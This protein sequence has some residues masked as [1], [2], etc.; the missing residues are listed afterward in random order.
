[1]TLI[2]SINEEILALTSPE[3]V[4]QELLDSE[5]YSLALDIKIRHARKF[6]QQIQNPQPSLNESPPLSS[7]TLNAEC[8][9]YIPQ[10][11]YTHSLHRPFQ[12]AHATTSHMINFQPS[13]LSTASNQSHQLP[14]LAL[15]TF[16][17]NILE[18][19]TFW[20]SYESAVHENQMLTN[21]QK[22]NYLKAQLRDE[23]LESITGF[24]LT[25]ANY[26][27]AVSVLTDRFG[28]TDKIINSYM[29]AL[30]E[31]QQPKNQLTSLRKFY[32]KMES[33]VRGL[34]A[35]GQSQE[36]YGKL[37]VPII[38]NKLPGEVRR[39]LAREHKS[40]TWMLRDLRKSI[41]EEI[42]IMDA[43]QE[44]QA[45]QSIPTTSFF[46]AGTKQTKPQR[47]HT[48]HKYA[49]H[50]IEKRPCIFCKD[51]HAPSA[52][53][54]VTDPTARMNIVKRD[55]LCFN[56]LGNHRIS[57]CKSKHTCKT[58]NKKHHT[59]LCSGRQNTPT[60]TRRNDQTE[61]SE[62]AVNKKDE[63][64]KVFHSQA[65]KTRS[66]VL[67][68]TAVAAVGSRKVFV[69]TNI[70]FDEGAQ[71]SFITS[72]LAKKLNLQT[73][74]SEEL[75]LS[76][77]GG[78]NN[79]SR[80]LERA[81]VYLKTDTGYRLP[82]NVLI[83]PR[84]ATPLHSNRSQ[85]DHRYEYLRGLKLAHPVCQDDAFEI[86]LLVGA[87]YY[88]D[89]IED[90]IVRGNGPTAV[91]SKIGYLLS[92]PV[93]RSEN[94]GSPTSSILNV[95]LSHKPE[96]FNLE[97]FWK[98]ESIGINSNETDEES[99]T[100]LE[101]YQENSIEFKD[102]K[103][104]AGLPWKKEHDELPT[105]FVVT[106][107]R[108]E[109]VI[110]R[111]SQKPDLLQ[112][113]G[114]IIADQERR[115]FIE[116]V[117][118]EDKIPDKVH[119]IPHHPVHKDSA[120]TPIR[121]VFDC[122]CRQSQHS[123]SLNDCLLDVPPKLNDLT[124]LLI[125]FRDNPV[126]IT[127]DI[128][129]AFLHVGLKEDDRDV[130][131]FLWLSDPSDPASS[132][133]TYR[134]KSVLFG[135]SCSPFILNATLLKHLRQNTC[136]TA[137][138]MER[139]LYVDNILSSVESDDE[140]LTY[141]TEARQI[142]AEAGF[143][144]RTWSSN[145]DKLRNLAREENV[146]DMDRNTKVLGMLWNSENDNL[147]YPE[148]N[149]SA[150]I[151]E[152]VTKRAILKHSSQ[153]YDPLGLLTPVTIRAKTLI[154]DLWKGGFDWDEKVPESHRKT[155]TDLV[156]DIDEI[157]ST[158]IPRTYFS[159]KSSST[160]DRILHVFTDA[161]LKAYGS[162]A[163][164]SNGEE[165]SLVMA[166][167]RVAPL[168]NLTLPQLELMAAV[169]GSRL[170]THIQQTLEITNIVFWSDSSIVLHWLKS[171][172]P[173]KR[174]VANRVNEITES[175][176]KYEWRYCPTEFN[177]ADLVT[178]GIT[179]KH[180]KESR[181][182]KY[183]PSWLTYSAK[184]P[185][186]KIISKTVMTTL[187]DDD[188]DQIEEDKEQEKNIGNIIN[189]QKYG[190][191]NTLIRITAYVQR[192]V[193][194]CTHVQN[195]RRHGTLKPCEIDNAT[196]TWISHTQRLVYAKE[197]SVLKD[198]KNTT[199]LARIRQLGLFMDDSDLIRCRGRINNA[200]IPDSAKYPLLMSANEQ[201][202]KLLIIDAHERTLHSG[203]NAT[204]TYVRQ[205]FWIPALRQYVKKIL[206]KCV[207]C[208]KVSG[209][210]YNA[211][212]AP[213]LPKIRLTEAPPFTVTGVDYTGA[214]LVRNDSGTLQKAYICLFTCASTR[215]VHL[216]VVPNLTE[217]SFVQ[218][219]RRFVSRKS[220]P[221]TL[222]SDNATTFISGSEEIK[223]LCDSEYIQETLSKHGI[224]WKFI[225][226]RAPWYG[227][228]WER[229]I[230]LTKTSLKKTL[231]RSQITMETLRTIVTEIETIL[232]DRPL[233]YPSSDI[234]DY[235]PLTPAHLL[236]GRKITS[237]PYPQ[238]DIEES[239]L[240]DISHHNVNKRVERQTLLIQHFW[241]RWK[242]EYLTSLR[243]FHR[244]TGKTEQSIREGD[245]VQIHDETPRT[246]WKLGLVKELVR[247]KDGLVRSVKIRT[248]TGE[249]TR[250][251]I[252]LY[253]LEISPDDT[254]TCASNAG[255]GSTRC[256]T[257]LRMRRKASVKARDNIRRWTN[258]SNPDDD[259]DVK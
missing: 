50:S 174:F 232:N 30:L 32:D 233:T 168:K 223:R 169:I 128:E 221:R 251:I 187:M 114:E 163:Y 143:N 12:N 235:E 85:I 226:K 36:T 130:T 124:K 37:L 205:S 90:H 241:R 228:F 190:S 209:R 102:N 155:W 64:T 45:P 188:R 22:F 166:K 26:E 121:I 24:A 5:D 132:L 111:L 80:N 243:E 255:G 167:T 99:D 154:Q 153:I 100:F 227:G 65:T 196:K 162:A 225:P 122:S 192:F 46:H 113:Y 126:A 87:D 148:R 135:A 246:N 202:S 14:K 249:T 212:T 245:I 184:W 52:C 83:V 78:E 239:D 247:G 40:N 208:K 186:N 29:Q 242:T 178:R 106:K 107:R 206:N 240:T 108:T 159:K 11:T 182:W 53:T 193:Y 56:C 1:M 224:E 2:D 146:L 140:A 210:P 161:S 9:P 142:M 104:F 136:K 93:D 105:N 197:Y 112:K 145:S 170:A 31:I 75:H 185:D 61:A 238:I 72:E 101:S 57:E 198:K 175:T 156:T 4:E 248:R 13:M 120:T 70:L 96:E 191:Y 92:G 131:R 48:T 172:K 138:T 89:I 115:G 95:M 218:A 203:L 165:S 194:N 7:H 41:R 27:E 73:E 127:T 43:G 137:G 139:D 118:N 94:K 38:L 211:P 17:G 217:H 44:A 51:M 179:A 234:R 81:T 39:N 149:F 171:T 20:D 183:G 19:Q 158:S 177:P 222:I 59:S 58:C 98:L 259:D 35:L 21:V 230:A 214:L 213:P 250:P 144:L 253:P 66:D 181:L 82:I 55:K 133:Q 77:F 150:S 91:K 42:N 25:N 67:L 258:G 74:G 180:F 47:N 84:I 23:A 3:D 117:E 119:Y 236:Y 257:E 28:Q 123:P 33:Y 16:S 237:L 252:K 18:W 141:Y 147:M 63:D 151:G 173:L 254:A 86:S 231:G 244:T 76:A 256:D 10:T 164:L 60:E 219:F 160:H 97:Q 199:K 204:V 229:L 110:M 157:M 215:A 207:K 34:E 134:F 195:D 69:D 216:E 116:K 125:R 176:K 49:Q 8:P 68:K 15:P 54:K 71:R 103:Y 88:W 62:T 201:F 200:P 152:N 129:K 109:N 79:K 6:V 220:L 189:I